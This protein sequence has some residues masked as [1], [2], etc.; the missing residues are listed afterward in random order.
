[1]TSKECL[2]TIGMT[3]TNNIK[4]ESLNKPR[5]M[6]LVKELRK[7]ELQTIKKDLDRLEEL[8]KENK[9]LKKDL[10]EYQAYIKKGVEEHYKDFMQ[11]YDVLLEEYEELMKVNDKL[12][13][14]L[15]VLEILKKYLGV[16]YEGK[17]QAILVTKWLLNDNQLTK[18]DFE[19]VKRWLE[20]E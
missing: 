3:K 7:K 1:M 19:K 16:G 11:D 8:E 10:K 12:K 20:N 18:E 9:L 13:K 17:K 4:S 15:E 2:E 6:Y 14:D 5:V